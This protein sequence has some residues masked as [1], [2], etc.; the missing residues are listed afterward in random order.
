MTHPTTH[1]TGYHEAIQ[2]LCEY[3]F[4]GLAEAFELLLDEV[5]KIERWRERPLGEIAYLVLDARYEHVR[6]GGTVVDMALLIAIGITHQY[7][8]TISKEIAAQQYP[9]LRGF[10]GLD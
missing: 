8:E 9:S 1:F 2:L 6:R 10:L 5:M 3:G 7:A 4:D